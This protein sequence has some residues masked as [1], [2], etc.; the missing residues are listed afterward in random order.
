MEFADSSLLNEN[1][2]YAVHTKSR[3]EKLVSNLISRKNIEVYL[4]VKKILR[5]WSDRKKLVDFPL[6]NGYLFV[7]MP[8]IEK[9]K[10]LH[11]KGVVRL[12]GNYAPECIPEEQIISLKKFETHDVEVDPYLH[13]HEGSQV[14]I[15]HGP[16]KDCT[17]Y[18]LRKKNK[19]RLVVNLE[20]IN[21]SVSVEIDSSDVE[22]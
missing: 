13:L 4:P 10:V 17:G 2:W 8:L 16:F 18:L 20:V 11:T 21:Q 22:G 6:F 3:H 5:K 7:N 19:Y 15:K 9:D 12:L 1:H 14:K